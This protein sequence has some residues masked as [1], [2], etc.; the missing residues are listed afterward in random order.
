MSFLLG[1]GGDVLGEPAEIGL[2]IFK[3]PYIDVFANLNITEQPTSFHPG[4]ASKQAPGPH[5]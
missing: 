2:F 3:E 1:V 4:Q 5:V